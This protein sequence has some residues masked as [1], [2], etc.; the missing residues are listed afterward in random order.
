MK[1]RRQIKDNNI[2]TR[3]CVKKYLQGPSNSSIT[4]RTI[5]S[6]GTLL[7][8]RPSPNSFE[9]RLIVERL[10]SIEMREGEIVKYEETE[11]D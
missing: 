3:C 11:R 8:E 6:A 10:K 7:A 5:S 9:R 4:T 2:H 1:E